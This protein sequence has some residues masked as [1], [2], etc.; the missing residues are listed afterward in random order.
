MSST[1]IKKKYYMY[2]IPMFILLLIGEYAYPCLSTDQFNK[3]MPWF[4]ENA[5]WSSNALSAPLTM[6]R[7]LGIP[8]TFVCGFCI[9]KIG[10]KKIFVISILS[11]GLAELLVTFSGPYPMYYLGL[12]VLNIMGTWILMSTFSL[13]NN[14]FRSWRGTALGIVT[15]I[16]PISSATIIKYM[17]YGVENMGYKWTFGLMSIVMLATAVAALILIR[18]TPEEIGCYPDAKEVAPPPEMLANGDKVDKIGIRQI[19][20]YKE[21]WLHP[22]AM[23]LLIFS[24]PVYS[25]FFTTRFAELGYTTGE[26]TAFTFGFSIFGALLSFISGVLDDKLGTHRA[27][28][29]M[30]VVFCIGTIGLRFGTPDRPWMMWFGII[31]LGGIVGA[32]PNLNPSHCV[33]TYGR[34]SFDQVYKYL[35][36][37]VCIPA[38][39]AMTFVTSLYEKTG[40]YDFAYTLMIPI[41]ICIVV[42]VLLM[43][44]QH[45]LTAEIK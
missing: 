20:R 40:S 43:N 26:M 11:Y 1:N 38:S 44:K 6:G 39:F 29:L 21:A 24:I 33:Y 28:I 45:D 34:K 23:G 22:I 25:G 7:A 30:T 13:C 8:L 35:N 31:S 3:L 16:S 4:M 15:M 12:C 32:T 17:N 18:E 14:W 10:A 37:L 2:M 19:F 36:T 5:G 42:C 9:N 41:S 27:T